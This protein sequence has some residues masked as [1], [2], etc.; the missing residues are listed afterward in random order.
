[1][2]TLDD[3]LMTRP[4]TAARP[5]LGVT[6]LVVEDSRFACEALRLL[7]LR[8]GAR[9]RRAD[10]LAH[11]RRHLQV[12]R[13]TCVI[14]D[15][16]LPDGDGAELIADLT[17]G[18]AA[19]Q[20]VLASSGAAD[21]EARAM[22]AGAHGYLPKP[23]ASIAAFQR[24][25]LSCLPAERQPK[26]PRPAQGDPVVPDP[27]ALRDD[28]VTAAR[29]LDTGAEDAAVD[30]VAQFLSG[31]ADSSGDR[32]MGD[33]VSRLLARRAAGGMGREELAEVSRLVQARLDAALPI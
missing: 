15:L 17:R 24:A 12:Y 31:I 19:I 11:A 2:D 5:L 32:P 30:Y 14:V 3:Y 33:A 25:I 10:S 16:G 28:L 26:G 1:M 29:R 6:V 27:L 7:C 18:S 21:G 9:I 20:V 22:A 8:S 13:P 4:P 23:I